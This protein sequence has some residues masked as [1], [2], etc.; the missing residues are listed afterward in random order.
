LRNYHHS[1]PADPTNG[2]GGIHINAQ[3]TAFRVGGKNSVTA[4]AK[5]SKLEMGIHTAFKIRELNPKEKRSKD[6]HL[7]LSGE[8]F[9]ERKGRT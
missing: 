3:K 2:K 8:G 9:G 7:F 4:F 6:P 1:K 5:G